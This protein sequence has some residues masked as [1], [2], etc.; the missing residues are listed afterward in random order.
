MNDELIKISLSW[1]KMHWGDKITLLLMVGIGFLAGVFIFS[2]ISPTSDEGSKLLFSA[3]ISMVFVAMWL[4]TNKVPKNK[5]DKIGFVIAI[6]GETAEQQI[7]IRNDFIVE[8][9]RILGEVAHVVPF[10]IIELPELHAIRIRDQKSAVYY[11]GKSKS[12][13]LVYGDVR[14]RN[15]KGKEVHSL[16]LEKLVVHKEVPLEVSAILASEMGQILPQKITIPCEDDLSGFEITT[17]W[18]SESVKFVIATAA[19]LSGDLALARNLLEEVRKSCK[20]LSRKKKVPG[21][22]TLLKLVPKRLSDAYLNSARYEYEIWR[23]TH[24]REHIDQVSY[25]ISKY[26]ELTPGTAQYYTMTAIS[27]FVAHRDV[28]GALAAIN[29]CKALNIA[30]PTWRFSV[31][32]LEAYQGNM[33]CAI[34]TYD[35]AFE[36]M[37]DGQ[38]QLPFEVEEFIAWVL[39]QEPDKYQLHYCLGL[40]NMHA[41]GDGVRARSDF[42]EFVDKHKNGDFSVVL[43]RAQQYLGEK[44]ESELAY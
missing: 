43:G 20:P 29:K 19:M 37:S 5:K 8:I 10:E 34:Q 31:A 9:R 21:A 40:L 2:M 41:K 4:L 1:F 14:T 32:F 24:E 39:V 28:K 42:Q 15:V 11:L 23:V 12:H 26:N 16:R 22:S 35:A 6:T 38:M 33:E 3:S 18:F 27:M 7:K 13:F 25:F 30:D 17:V 44:I 36:Q